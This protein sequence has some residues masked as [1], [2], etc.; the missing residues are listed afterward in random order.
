MENK[1]YFFI[2]NEKS[3]IW[4]ICLR[5]ESKFGDGHLDDFQKEAATRGVL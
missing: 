5:L 2:S 3:I 1:Q 4:D